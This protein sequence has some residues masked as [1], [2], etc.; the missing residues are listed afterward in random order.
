MCVEAFAKTIPSVNIEFQSIGIGRAEERV[1]GV[2]Q[3]APFHLSFWA[4][5]SVRPPLWL[6]N[7]SISDH[8][9]LEMTDSSGKKRSRVRFDLG[10]HAFHR[11]G[12]PFVTSSVQGRT[13][14]MPGP[15][16][17]WVKL[18]GEFLVPVARLRESPVYE[19]PLELKDGVSVPVVLQ[20]DEE[21]EFTGD[22][23][24]LPESFKGEIFLRGCHVLEKEGRKMVQV[25][26]R[27]ALDCPMKVDSLQILDDKGGVICCECLEQKWT[28]AAAGFSRSLEKKVQMAYK[29]EMKKIGIR[30][31]YVSRQ[32]VA[33][34]PVDVKFGMGGEVPSGK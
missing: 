3:D 20:R 29:E 24:V 19:L 10:M 16:V 22:V 6:M 12:E 25:E 17:P 34:V 27:L 32:D 8:Q 14:E 15:D 2:V 21:E 11:E 9:F 7:P 31:H 23:A 33:P 5:L 28:W 30:F 1:D 13:L 26:I 18:K 4:E